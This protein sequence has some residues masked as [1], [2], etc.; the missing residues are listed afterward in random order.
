VRDRLRSLLGVNL[1]PDLYA[2][3]VPY[4]WPHRARLAGYLAITVLVTGLEL[5]VP[6]PLKILVD[7][8]LRDGPWPAVIPALAPGLAALSTLALIVIIVISGLAL[9]LV[10]SALGVLGSYVFT[11]TRLSIVLGLRSDLFQHF[12]RLS[13]T[14]HENRRGGDLIYRVSSD[15]Y[16]IDD[17]VSSLLPLVT[18]ALTLAG[19]F[20][21]TFHLDW[22]I[23]LLSL[24]VAPFFY[25]TIAVYSR[26]FEDRV[27][28]IQ[29]MESETVSIV[30]EVLAGLRVVK[31]FTQEDHEHSRFLRQGLSA[32]RARVRLSLH[33]TIYSMLAAL[34][35]AAGSALVLGVGAYHVVQG[36]LTLGSLLVILAYLSSIYGP[37]DSISSVV[38]YM[39]QHLVKMGRVFEILDTEPDVRD[40]AGAVPLTGI[41]GRVVF[42]AVGFAYPERGSV[43][44]DVSFEA[45]PGQ[46]IGIVG[47]TG[48]GKST[49]VSLIPRFYD[50]GAG[51]VLVDGHD[52]R[53]VRLK[54]LRQQ[55]G[56]VLQD[57]ILFAGTIADNI[58]YGR[59]GAT[60]DLIV[61]AARAANAHEFILALPHGY[62]TEVG[63]R[64]VKLSGGERQRISIARAFLKDA[65]ILILDEPT[66]AVDSRTEAAILQALERLMRGRTTFLVAHRLS[67]VRRADQI[68]VLERGRIAERGTHAELLAKG[69]SYKEIY[70]LQIQFVIPV[71][72]PR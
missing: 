31:A 42:D 52:V 8:V 57:T 20:W 59:L 34:I 44:R 33:Q 21:I 35:T 15:T 19:M 4:L 10:I 27:T 69:G 14:F 11:A 12:Q 28:E 72:G 3:L 37:L 36:S 55:I 22:E 41:S 18:A 40:R 29:R 30:Q 38:T 54:S 43:L 50:V 66:S 58:R 6:W 64:G 17:V 25:S 46:V 71:E 49:L 65:P 1:R 2:R 24:L 23:A 13:L 26:I 56:L 48:A 70:D 63:E 7:S 68:L 67:T 47:L 9:R 32:V 5:L 39:S 53:G 60:F 16:G 51:H 61:E 62:Q 45:R